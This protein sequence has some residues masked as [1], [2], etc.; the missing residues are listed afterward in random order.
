MNWYSGKISMKDNPFAATL[1]C[2]TTQAIDTVIMM[3]CR[4]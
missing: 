2:S 1:S 3:G 4:R